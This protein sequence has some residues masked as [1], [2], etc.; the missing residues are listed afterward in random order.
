MMRYDKHVVNLLHV[1][2]FFGNFQGGVQQRISKQSVTNP[3]NTTHLF[4]LK[5]EYMFRLHRPSSGHYFKNFQ[6][7]LKYKGGNQEF[8]ELL[9]KN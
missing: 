4:L 2:A 1:S 9:K 5:Q 6:N 3:S 7:N 8:P